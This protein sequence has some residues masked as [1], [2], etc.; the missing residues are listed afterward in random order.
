M[1]VQ[2]QQGRSSAAGL[3][4]RNQLEADRMLTMGSSVPV[5]TL[6]LDTSRPS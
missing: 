2:Q 3:G 1:Q 4:R 5:W 6:G